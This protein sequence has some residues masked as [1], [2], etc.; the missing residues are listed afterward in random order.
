[1]A[2]QRIPINLKNYGISFGRLTLKLFTRALGP[3]VS[4]IREEFN[5][6]L[7]ALFG[8]FSKQ[9]NLFLVN[10]NNLFLVNVNNLFSEILA[11]EK[12]L[13][14]WSEFNKKKKQEWENINCGKNQ[15]ENSKRENEEFNNFVPDVPPKTK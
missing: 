11:L 5:F 8:I 12:T 6:Q 3:L 14:F 7:N 2:A 10:V 4:P 9:K 13:V 1:M 15:R